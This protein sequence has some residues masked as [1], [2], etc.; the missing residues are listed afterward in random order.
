M[1]EQREAVSNKSALGWIIGIN[2]TLVVTGVVAIVSV[3]WSLNTALIKVGTTQENMV[4]R[5]TALETSVTVGT[6]G[7]YTAS[8][9]VADRTAILATFNTTR[10]AWSQSFRGLIDANTKLS[11]DVADLRV[12]LAELGHK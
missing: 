5:I 4:S 2:S 7:R 12:K 6:Q 10:E 8:D 11:T 9:A 3:L 1:A